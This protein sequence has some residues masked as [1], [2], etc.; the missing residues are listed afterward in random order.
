MQG[1]GDHKKSQKIKKDFRNNNLKEQ[2]IYKAF[3]FHSEGNIVEANKYYK[4]FISQGFTDV[5]VFSNY[6]V[7]LKGLES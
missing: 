6:G 5:K 1:F 4:F 7:L 3:K 2:I